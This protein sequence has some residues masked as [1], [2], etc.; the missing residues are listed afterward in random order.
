MER[1]GDEN[2][3]PEDDTEPALQCGECG[4]Y[5]GGCWCGEPGG[6]PDHVGEGEE[7]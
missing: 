5:D 7:S 4:K 2:N 6:N 1:T 3:E